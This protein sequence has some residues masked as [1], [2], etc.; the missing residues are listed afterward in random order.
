MKSEK[1]ES[2]RKLRVWLNWEADTAD[3][4]QYVYRTQIYR[5]GYDLRYKYVY[6]LIETDSQRVD[7]LQ[8]AAS[9]S[10]NPIISKFVFFLGFDFYRFR[11]LNTIQRCELYIKL[12]TP[13]APSLNYGSA[14]PALLAALPLDRAPPFSLSL[15]PPLSPFSRPNHPWEAS[16]PH[17]FQF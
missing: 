17:K 13:A 3:C 12:S 8:T 16:D 9:P 5:Y 6:G 7:L 1:S 4:E 10:P 2:R 15:P 11:S 14:L